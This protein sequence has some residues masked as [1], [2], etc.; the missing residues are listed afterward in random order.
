VRHGRLFELASGLGRAAH[1][2]QLVFG[3]D[4]ESDTRGSEMLEEENQGVDG[5]EICEQGG[6]EGGELLDFDAL[7]ACVTTLASFE[8]GRSRADQAAIAAR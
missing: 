8:E 3:L 5:L 2:F 4:Q 1:S 7:D 6:I